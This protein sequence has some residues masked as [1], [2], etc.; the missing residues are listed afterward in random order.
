MSRTRTRKRKKAV[1]AATNL[2]PAKTES[3]V[4]AAKDFVYQETDTKKLELHKAFLQ[5]LK[6]DEDV[7]L[8]TIEQKTSQLFSQTGIIVAVLALFIPLIIEKVEPISVRAFFISLL[9]LAGFFYLRTI[10]AA[11]RNLEI[12]KFN[13]Q[14]SAASTVLNQDLTTPE[15]FMVEEINDLLSSIPVQ[16]ELNNEKGSNLLGAHRSFKIAN[17]LTGLLSIILCSTIALTYQKSD[18][19]KV[20]VDGVVRTAPEGVDSHQEVLKVDPNP[21]DSNINRPAINNSEHPVA[22]IR[23]DANSNTKS[24]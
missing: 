1:E 15:M 14:R 24:P 2:S 6:K 11:G 3:K 23:E 21:Q 18:V 8:T 5:A 9:S 7:R 20:H 19:T 17:V 4:S 13:Y 10:Y 12:N 22:P 16:I